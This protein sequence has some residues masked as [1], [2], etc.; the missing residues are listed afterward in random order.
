MTAQSLPVHVPLVTQPLGLWGSL[1]A[2]R[3]NILSII[4]EIATR[5]PMVSGKTGKRWHMVM[6]PD[7]LKQVLLEKLDDYPKSDVTK[8]LLR[9]AIGESLFVAE[10]A[11][12]R[13][14]RRAAA[15]A[16]SHRNVSNLAPIMSKAAENACR[17]I[18]NAGP[19]G[20]VADPAHLITI[21]RN[22]PQHRQHV[23]DV[24]GLH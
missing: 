22:N 4:P 16:F 10:G 23:F 7:A 21:V 14:Q 17:R 20:Q 1:T 5:Q 18:A 9:P 19:H 2:A 6:D 13:W 12:W 24:R 3:R 15:P 8:N 11:H